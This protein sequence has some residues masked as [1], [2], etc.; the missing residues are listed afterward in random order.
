MTTLDKWRIG[1]ISI[2][3]LIVLLCSMYVSFGHSVDLIMDYGQVGKSAYA[4]VIM[5]ETAFVV[6][7]ISTALSKLQGKTMRWFEWIFFGV[8]LSY[9]G[10]SN[11][12]AFPSTFGGIALGIAIPLY[13]FIM[14]V[15]LSN[16][17]ISILNKPTETEKIVVENVETLEEIQQQ[18][19]K[20]IP[21][22]MEHVDLN[23]ES[24]PTKDKPTPTKKVSTTPTKLTPAKQECWDYI[25]DYVDKNKKLP[26]RRE[27][28]DAGGFT[29]WVSAD[30]LRLYKKEKNIA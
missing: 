23:V 8:G 15:T 4:I 10:W 9:V 25:V 7:S 16:V 24:S 30:T 22:P 26:V 18:Q 3:G 27:L 14:E 12:H 19:Q 5:L 2:G 20:D 1:I 29:D 17:V 11:L 21:T 13:L 6:F 28:V